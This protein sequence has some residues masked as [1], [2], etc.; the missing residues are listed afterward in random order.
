MFHHQLQ[1]SDHIEADAT[2]DAPFNSPF[3]ISMKSTIL[4]ERLQG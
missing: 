2:S 1:V 3:A 4:F